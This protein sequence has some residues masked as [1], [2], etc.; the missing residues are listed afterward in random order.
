MKLHHKAI[1]SPRRDAWCIVVRRPDEIVV[2][3]AR[4]RNGSVAGMV[5]RNLER[6]TS[7][8]FAGCLDRD[9]TEGLQNDVRMS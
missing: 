9:A 4:M 7:D 8:D 6:G 1:H 3:A 5:C 2:V